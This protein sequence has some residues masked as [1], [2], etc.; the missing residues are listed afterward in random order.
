MLVLPVGC[1]GPN[2]AARSGPAARDLTAAYGVEVRDG[3][4]R[5]R[6]ATARFVSLD[7]AVAAGYTRDVA[8][9]YADDGHG[10]MGFHH[11]NRGLWDARIEVE[12]PEI[13]LFERSGG[14]YVLNGVEYI[15]PYSRWPRDSIAPTVMG[16]ALKRSDDLRLWYLHAWIWT[17]NPSGLF[18]DWHPAVR[19]PAR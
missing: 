2:Q 18:A 16:Q 12:R 7:S 1:A 15:V 5:V 8:Q 17:E 3:V 19:C 10:A 14:R 11:A 9:C 13:L 4:E 6:A